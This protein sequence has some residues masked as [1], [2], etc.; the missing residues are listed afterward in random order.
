[1]TLYKKCNNET[2]V[3]NVMNIYP[4]PDSLT[5]Q[6][7]LFLLPE[8]VFIYEESE[9]SASA[10]KVLQKRVPFAII[11][12]QKEE[13]HISF[14]YKDCEKE[15]YSISVHTEGIYITAA[16][17]RGFVNAVETL[18]QMM[19]PDGTV[20][21]AELSDKPYKQF[22][23]IHLYMP[24]SAYIDECK[25]LFD[26]LSY[27]K[28]NTVI[29]EVGGTMEYKKHPEVNRAWVDFCE[30][31]TKKFP[32]GP[33]NFQWSDRYW[34]DSTHY[35]NAR[36]EIL[37][38]ETVRDLVQYAKDLG[39][40]VIPEIQSLSHAY[41]LTLAHREIAEDQNDLFPDTYCPLNEDS[42]ALYFDIASEVLDV[43]EPEIVSIGHDEIRIMGE[44][45]KCK[46]KT[47]HE[48]LAYE[49]NRLHAFYKERN[50]R[51][52]MWCERLMT[53]K[54]ADKEILQEGTDAYG[55]K[56]RLPAM[57]KA[58]DSL[59]KDV[60]ML[61]WYHSRA[62]QTEKEYT[63]KGFDAW[64]GNFSG[65]VFGNWEERSSRIKGAEI[66]TWCTPDEF[67]LG[68]NGV[69]FDLIFSA[70][71][72]WNQNYSD[73]VYTDFLHTAMRKA[74]DVRKIIC[75][76]KNISGKVEI[77]YK[78][79][80][81]TY[82]I[83]SNAYCYGRNAEELMKIC[84]KLSGTPVDTSHVFLETDIYAESLL[85]CEA[86]KK[87][88]EQQMSYNYITAEHWDSSPTSDSSFLCSHMPRWTAATHE[89]LYEDG[90]VE[91][92]NATYGITAADV[93]MKYER[94]CRYSDERVNEIDEKDEGERVKA[95]HYKLSDSWQSSV[96]YFSDTIISEEYTAYVYEWKNPYPDK[97][98]KKIKVISTTHDKE[99]SVILFAIGYKEK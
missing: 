10:C 7:G 83:D 16:D 41:Y 88:E 93:H 31:L 70:E 2:G 8:T 52:M 25:R 91:L 77:L 78:T 61:D 13:A 4:K 59:P 86:F 92:A 14:L 18:L 80:V 47:G 97:K 57:Y 37:S 28:Y 43:F 53:P 35:E 27:L 30:M 15:E 26:A 94:L 33:Q 19:H 73:T 75:P 71:M 22:R 95:P 68:R 72:F 79:N 51:I 49:I 69:L 23:G 21:C 38:Q 64:F 62:S 50:V 39:L 89:I 74:E 42:Y 29:L 48:L 76:E 66:S 12:G 99:Q 84:G 44:C 60:I 55:R 82:K 40:N 32:G 6:D 36:G 5:L 20:P 9:I 1:M 63:D 90:T 45:P 85:L 56:Y 98:I 34:K 96:L 46:E 11:K 65:I 81:D 87:P 67:T 24:A 3:T 54:D 58:I 17:K